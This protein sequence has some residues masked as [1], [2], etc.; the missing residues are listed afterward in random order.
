[1]EIAKYLK[2][3]NLSDCLLH[4]SNCEYKEGKTFRYVSYDFVKEIYFHDI[5][6][7]CHYCFI[8]SSVKP[9]QRTSTTPYTLWTLLQ[10]DKNDQPGSRTIKTNCSCTARILRCCNHVVAM[11][12][13]VEVAVM[14]GLTKSTCTSSKSSWKVSKGITT[15]FDVVPVLNNPKLKKK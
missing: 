7:T 5:S 8:R 13:R 1:M 11:L 14:Q 9:S 10:E 15:T 3:N 6:D 2:N 4:R 12:F